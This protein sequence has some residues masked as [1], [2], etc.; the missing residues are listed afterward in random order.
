MN[1]S[2]KFEIKGLL[3]KKIIEKIIFKKSTLTLFS[4]QNDAENP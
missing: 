4:E 1:G 2:K 3:K